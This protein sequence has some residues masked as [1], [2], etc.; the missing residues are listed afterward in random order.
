MRARQDQTIARTTLRSGLDC[1]D[2]RIVSTSQAFQQTY[3]AHLRILIR[4]LRPVSVPWMLISDYMMRQ[5][6]SLTVTV[7]LPPSPTGVLGE[8]S[9]RITLSLAIFG[10]TIDS[11]WL[12]K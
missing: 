6:V 5:T 8:K 12:K 3:D 9:K 10:D 2:D 11:F 7:I 1:K 4:R